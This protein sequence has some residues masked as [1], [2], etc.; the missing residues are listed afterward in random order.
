[1]NNFEIE[2]MDTALYWN[3][4]GF[5]KRN[6]EI[7]LEFM[8]FP[9]VRLWENNFYTAATPSNSAFVTSVSV[10]LVPVFLYLSNL[11]NNINNF[12]RRI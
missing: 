3:E 12:S 11:T 1:M 4:E 6:L 7:C 5:N 8:H 10:L 2:A 9:H